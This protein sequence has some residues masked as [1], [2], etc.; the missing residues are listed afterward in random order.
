MLATL[1]TSLLGLLG[2]CLAWHIFRSKN[3]PHQ[4]L[5]CPLSGKCSKVIHSSYN[6]LAGL[7]LEVWGLGYYGLVTISSIVKLLR[8]DTYSQNSSLLIILISTIAF[9][10]SIYLTFIQMYRLRAWCTW[11]L[12]SAFLCSLIF[13]LTIVSIG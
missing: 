11:C 5:I 12:C 9:L 7:P 4:P 2:F 13:A 10:F 3:R 6:K 1:L 8:P